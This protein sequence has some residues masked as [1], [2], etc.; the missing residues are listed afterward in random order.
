MKPLFGYPDTGWFGNL[1]A[2]VWMLS[3]AGG[4]VALVIGGVWSFIK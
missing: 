1:C 4:I 2:N 3:M